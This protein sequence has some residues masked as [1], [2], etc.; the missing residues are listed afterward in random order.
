MSIIMLKKVFFIFTTIGFLQANTESY[1]EKLA[2]IDVN[3]CEGLQ[4][5][6]APEDVKRIGLNPSDHNVINCL[7]FSRYTDGSK[8]V[9]DGREVL[10]D[11]NVSHEVKMGLLAILPNLP[12]ADFETIRKLTQDYGQSFMMLRFVQMWACQRGVS[13]VL[14]EQQFIAF[15]KLA[16]DFDPENIN[17][18]LA[19]IN[20]ACKFADFNSA[21]NKRP[22]GSMDD[23]TILACRFFLELMKIDGNSHMQKLLEHHR[24]AL[25]TEDQV[26]NRALHPQFD[27]LK[28]E[29]IKISGV[30]LGDR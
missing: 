14:D 22:D 18:Y 3:Q 9:R 16:N 2:T 15:I 30:S 26:L 24:Q 27:Y 29:M 17:N 7:Y 10:R 21:E 1:F 19:K 12:T 25:V 23:E 13:L 28:E 20:K 6:I 11:M 8:I 4:I 5:P